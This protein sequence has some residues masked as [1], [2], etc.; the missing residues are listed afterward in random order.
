MPLTRNNRAYTGG[1]FA[2]DIEGADGGW[3]FSVEGGMG[4]AEVLSERC[5]RDHRVQKHIGAVKYDD[6]TIT[7][8]PGMS[9]G[10]FHWLK[11]SFEEDDHERKNGA[12]I[13]ADYDYREVTRLTFYEGLVTE[14]GFPALD[15]TSRDMARLTVKISPEYIH[16]SPA[17]GPC[18][19]GRFPTDSVRAKRWSVRNFRIR[20]D[21]IDCRR[22][23]KIEALHL[24]Q[25]V[26]E[27]PF[28]E[29]GV[30]CREPTG[31]EYPNL[32]LSL[33]ESHADGFFRWYDSFVLK[34]RCSQSDEKTGTIELLHEDM[35]TV[36]C[37]IDLMQLGIF[38]I[39]PDKGEAGSE[40]IRMV[41]VE[42]YCE[43]MKFDLNP[44]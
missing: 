41:K 31:I 38:K 33:P 8:G 25:R 12:I 18:I 24:R 37:S 23:A 7:C 34:N 17:S 26:T 13:T 4:H 44:G 6:I 16:F 27:V 40:K 43:E 30:S 11:A 10:F 19:A 15:A 3:L 20:I 14:L 5:S 32:V 28:G 39:T 29:L 22:V 21:G 35:R 1:H 9:P 2:L 42:M 36:M